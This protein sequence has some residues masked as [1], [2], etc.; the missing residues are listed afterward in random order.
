MAEIQFADDAREIMD[1]FIASFPEAI[2]ESYKTK[3]LKGV[4]YQI[5]KKGLTLAS[6]DVF[7][8]ALYEAFPKSFEPLLLR[9]KDPQKLTSMMTAQKKI[10]EEHPLVKVRRW[11][12]PPLQSD[13]TIKNVFALMASPRKGGSTDSIMDTLLE[14]VAESGCIIEKLYI[15]DL[16]ISPCIG[17]MACEAKKLET[18]CAVKDDMTELYGKFLGCDAFV[19]GFPVYTARECAQA[20]IF[21]DRLKALRTK[22]QMHKLA[23][24]RR[25]AL[26]VT[27][28]WPT[29]DSYDHV[30][31]SAL[32]V[33]NLFGV[34]T[35]EVVTGSGFWE[36]YYKKGT[37]KL[38]TKGM[39]Q[40][41]EAGRALVSGS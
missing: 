16:T 28:G 17:C 24:K 30:V 36:A 14:G 23:N 39:E 41:R 38:D 33:L 1:Q 32:F 34:D 11:A 37:A 6:K 9:Y 25:G 31:E 21:F 4:E 12:I 26:V 10:D 5:L 15:S 20:A 8:D 27:W 35:A 13:K 40:A 2:K 19:M 3:V 29:E 18:Y 22:G 7:I